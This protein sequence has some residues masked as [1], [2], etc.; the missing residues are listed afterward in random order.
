MT[1]PRI[2]LLTTFAAVTLGAIGYLLHSTPAEV[3][4]LLVGSVA[5]GM[6]LFRA[7]P[8]EEPPTSS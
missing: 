1:R 2:A 5:L 6:V 3:V 4:S 8:A 7:L